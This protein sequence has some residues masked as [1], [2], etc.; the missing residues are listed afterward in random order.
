MQFS[1]EE[2][3]LLSSALDEISHEVS[4]LTGARP[5]RKASLLRR[6][7]FGKDQ[8][9][10]DVRFGYTISREGI[11]EFGIVA[12]LNKPCDKP[13]CFMERLKEIFDDDDNLEFQMPDIVS[14]TYKCCLNIDDCDFERILDCIKERIL[15]RFTKTHEFVQNEVKA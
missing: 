11:L 5:S 9:F 6:F 12:K 10:R 3:E 1:E 7:Y 4:T 2:I 13:D 14:V 8:I 15:L